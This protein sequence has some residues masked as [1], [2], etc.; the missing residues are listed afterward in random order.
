MEN[1]IVQW[2]TNKKSK[3]PNFANLQVVDLPDELKREEILSFDVAEFP[4]AELVKE[5]L[6]IGV[7]AEDEGFGGLGGV[8]ERADSNAST[9]LGASNSA[10]EGQI[11]AGVN[12]QTSDQDSARAEIIIA[13]N[14]D[15]G[16][17]SFRLSQ[18]HLTPAGQHAIQYPARRSGQDP[19]RSRWATKMKDPIFRRK[20]DDLFRKFIQKVVAPS[21]RLPRENQDET[22]KEAGNGAKCEERAKEGTKNEGTATSEESAQSE[23]STKSEETTKSGESPESETQIKR[24]AAATEIRPPSSQKRTLVYQAMP[25]LRVHMPQVKPVGIPHTDADYFHQPGEV[26]FWWPV[27][28]DVHDSNS[29]FAESEPKKGDFRPFRAKYGECVKFYGNKCRHYTV[30]NETETTRVSLD[31]RVIPMEFY[32]D[33][34]SK[35]P[36][37]KMAEP[38]VPFRLGG[39]FFLLGIWFLVSVW[40]HQFCLIGCGFIFLLDT[41]WCFFFQVKLNK[42]LTIVYCISVDASNLSFIRTF[43]T[44]QSRM[45]DGKKTCVW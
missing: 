27:D 4:F 24:K 8:E 23:E 34:W 10:E 13:E 26:N 16:S 25:S 31:I 33:D 28:C 14:V 6:E 38:V 7:G 41:L 17:P 21:L 19:F 9:E 40:F 44:S 30:P 11:I 39:F 5:A 43:G 45:T 18:L 36:T 42:S 3:D 37:R 29:L 15:P 2:K 1:P 20:L 32:V 35:P 22:T 12:R